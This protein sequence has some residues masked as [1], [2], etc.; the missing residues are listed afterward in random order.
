MNFSRI[1][2]ESH[3]NRLKRNLHR[4]SLAIAW[5]YSKTPIQ[6]TTAQ[7]VL[8]LLTPIATQNETDSLNETD[9]CSK[10]QPWATKETLSPISPVIFST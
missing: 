6:N 2:D 4:S 9:T 8:L 10:P 7:V 1:V 3:Q 5:T